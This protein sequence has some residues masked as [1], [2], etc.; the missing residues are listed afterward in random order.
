METTNKSEIERK[1]PEGVEQ[2]YSHHQENPAPSEEAVVEKNENGA[3]LAMKWIIPICLIILL[4][5]YLI[6]RE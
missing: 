2:D 4:I 6:V 1:S 5:V 3:G